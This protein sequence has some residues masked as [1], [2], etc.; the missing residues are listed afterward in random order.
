M[1]RSRVDKS[2]RTQLLVRLAGFWECNVGFRTAASRTLITQPITSIFWERI[3]FGP[4]V[5]CLSQRIRH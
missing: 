2:S 4:V 1:Q 5:D 3:F